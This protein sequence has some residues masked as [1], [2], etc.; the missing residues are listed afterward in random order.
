MNKYL[1]LLCLPAM[2]IFMF[3]SCSDDDDDGAGDG[4]G[5]GHEVE[6]V[7]ENLVGEWICYYQHWEEGEDHQSESYYNDDNLAI[8]FNE[9][10]SG[11]LKSESVYDELLETRAE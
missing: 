4:E 2:L 10:R 8:T 7:Y 1:S 5:G 3:A 6:V 11:F 9:D